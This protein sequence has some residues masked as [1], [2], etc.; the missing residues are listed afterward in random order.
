MFYKLGYKNMLQLLEEYKEERT[1]H[2]NRENESILVLEVMNPSNEQIHEIMDLLQV[3]PVVTSECSMHHSIDKLDVFGY[4]EYII[5]TSVV[6]G[7]R[8]TP[9]R[10]R[11]RS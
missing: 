10:R 6:V 1:E 3:E 11:R 8:L 7:A 9:G 5:H 4:R 2:M